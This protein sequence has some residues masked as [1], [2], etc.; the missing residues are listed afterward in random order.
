MNTNFDK[1][2]IWKVSICSTVAYLTATVPQVFI[3]PL[4]KH[5]V[6][7]KAR[8]YPYALCFIFPLAIALCFATFRVMKKS[9]R[10]ILDVLP[11]TLTSLA[12]VLIF[13]PEIPHGNL[14]T[15]CFI[16]LAI[17]ILTLW[18]RVRRAGN[19]ADANINAPELP[20]SAKIEYLKEE[21]QYWRTFII[22]IAGGYIAIIISWANFFLAYNKGEVGGNEADASI[23]NLHALFLIG[24]CSIGIIVCPLAEAGR[25]HRESTDLF[26]TIKDKAAVDTPPRS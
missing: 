25:K 13:T 14:F 20:V 17:V 5:Q 24:L 8:E 10:I 26:L 23:L 7:Y 1:S 6:L 21:V 3:D 11:F 19:E 4:L 22:G 2:F 16:W 9:E 15:V 12:S 18:I